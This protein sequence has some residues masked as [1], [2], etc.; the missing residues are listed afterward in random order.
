MTIP[1]RRFLILLLA[2]L[3][4]PATVLH[5]VPAHGTAAP[6]ATVS[7][8]SP[9][10]A[11]STERRAP[12][13]RDHGGFR[14]P[15]A[16]M[17]RPLGVIPH[18]PCPPPP[19]S[20]AC[21]GSDDT[22]N[23]DIIMGG[24]P[25]SIPGLGVPLGGIGAGSFMINQAGTFGP[26][27]FGGGQSPSNEIRALTQAAFHVREQVGG[28]KP[29]VRTLATKGPKNVGSEGKVEA[30]SWESPLPAWKVLEPGEGTYAALYPFG[31]TTYKPFRTDVSLQFW[32]P[33]VAREERRTSLPVAY[34]D[35]RL[36]NPTPRPSRVSVMFTMPNAPAH[37][38]SS[39]SHID[40]DIPASR[41][42]GF[43]SRLRTD[44]ASG[45]SAVVLRADAR[46][47]TPDTDRSQW[48]LAADPRPGQHLSYATSWNANGRGADVYRPFVRKGALPDRRLDRS[49]SA[50]ALSVDTRLAPG[51]STTV[52]FALAWDFP[53]IAYAD[54][55]S[56]WM[57]RYT[58]FYGARRAG[59]N[60]Y[61]PGSYPFHQGFRIARDAL[62]GRSAALRAVRR[63]WRPIATRR[64]Y[65]RVLRRA[66]LN[67][68][69]HIAWQGA[70]WENGLVRS[71]TE[72]AGG[73][74]LGSRWPQTHVFS[75]MDSNGQNDFDEMNINIYGYLAYNH[76]FPTLER[77]RL[78]TFADAAMLDPNGATPDY[79]FEATGNPFFTWAQSTGPAAPGKSF[80]LDNPSKFIF[81]CLAYARINHDTRF[82]RRVFPAM[83]RQLAFL[84]EHVPPG[85]NLPVD[86]PIFP[87]TYNVIPI[88]GSSLY[89]SQL[90]LLALQVMIA[91]SEKVG[92]DASV[93]EEL[94]QT[95][96]AAKAE[97][98]LVF[99]DP[100]T[101]RYRPATGGP[102]AAAVQLE[103]FYGQHL[104]RSLGL[105]D[106]VDPARMAAELR[107]HHAE[108]MATPPGTQFVGA[109]NFTA[110]GD[111]QAEAVW[112]GTSFFTAG[113]WFEA[114]K[115]FRNGD[116][117]R[118]GLRLA[119]AVAREIWNDRRNGYEFNA[120]EGWQK[121][122]TTRNRYPSYARAL[123]IWEILNA[124]R[125]LR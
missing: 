69:G 34:F 18:G 25:L 41:R 84:R 42:S 12:S 90:Y 98:E 101:E 114:S 117:R 105:P 72:P 115:R 80:F 103:A 111:L 7:A 122:D 54:N 35:V 24:F 85:A 123:S 119:K 79:L 124:I 71:R 37:K 10:A 97:F 89:N 57:R 4:L 11:R 47:N 83:K 102:V 50:G 40:P 55:T 93:I 104:A 58:G 21:E 73:L 75:S 94:E 109:P 49:A 107:R 64:E 68:L 26:W 32:S 121:G 61:I 33:I 16:A 2:S 28:R 110:G 27:N 63:W 116:L 100:V 125:P 106:L 99:W 70:F 59:D 91:A 30:R 23:A 19:S 60:E 43:S 3:G 74:R 44:P 1:V 92:E 66:A 53:Q 5:P 8:P 67:Q 22:T 46:T 62:E 82:L 86:S 52:R 120:P 65:P 95:L 51:E 81:R 48:A 77:D 87:N 20:R 9:A 108:F 31:W 78:H 112:S 45:V 6:A 56:V 14:I 96:E 17:R 38:A 36:T 29:F 13:T 88:A 118:A 15:A 76:F 39:L 113:T